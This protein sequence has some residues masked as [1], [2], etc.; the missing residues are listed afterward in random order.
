MNLLDR[1]LG[2]F[3]Q[4]YQQMK[5]GLHRVQ[6]VLQE[7]GNPQNSY[8][9]IL[10]AG[11]N[12]KGSVARMVE[13]V[14]LSA[15]Q[16]VGLYTSPHLVRFQERIRVGGV[17]VSEEGLLAI[18]EDIQIPLK[19]DAEGN[20]WTPHQEKLSWFEKVTVLTFEVF[21]REK[22]S[23]AILEVGLGGRLDATNVVEPLLS[24]ITSIS[25]DHTE[26][27]GNSI[28]L[29]AREKAGVMRKGKP[30]ILG[31]LDSTAL[32]VLEMEAEL[33]EALPILVGT[34][35][36]SSTDFTYKKYTQLS[37]PLLGNHQLKNVAV[38]I[39][40]LEKL[41]ASGF[42]VTEEDIDQGLSKTTHPGRL[43]WMPTKPPILLD[44]AHN[45]E[46]LH[47][48]VDYLKKEVVGKKVTLVLAMM[49]DK[50]FQTALKILQPYV[51][52]W[53]FTEIAS[54]RCVK[55]SQWKELSEAYRISAG[56][57]GDPHQ[58]LKEAFRITLE[59]EVILITG[60]FYLIGTFR[61]NYA[62]RKT[63]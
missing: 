20:C 27:L 4:E 5:L 7:L 11:T 46:A 54:P 42:S 8:P 48:L 37:I 43:E 35:R 10:I 32:Q 1:F 9:S 44:G 16:K 19:L 34:P 22:I 23:L 26:I 39:E 36:G 29:I 55:I 17:E 57:F 41:N 21:R 28:E 3:S 31:A 62:A 33:V 61:E 24:A 53:I 63:Y 38:S 40:I 50:D 58:A 14:L 52:R 59:N 45:P 15:G 60:S 56:F 6:E 30:V 49:Q 13:S 18:L 2:N 12:G 47:A 51:H 25:L